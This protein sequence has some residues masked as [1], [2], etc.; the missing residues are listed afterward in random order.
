[1]L[2][3]FGG[4]IWSR[5]FPGRLCCGCCSIFSLGFLTLTIFGILYL[6]K[7]SFEVQELGTLTHV[8]ERTDPIK[9]ING[10]QRYYL[11]ERFQYRQNQICFLYRQNQSFSKQKIQEIIKEMKLGTQRRI[12]IRKGH[13]C[14]DRK[15]KQYYL[16]TGFG[17]LTPLL[18]ILSI[19]CCCCCLYSCYPLYSP[20]CYCCCVDWNILACCLR[21]WKL[22][23]RCVCCDSL[24][25]K[26]LR[27]PWRSMRP[28]MQRPQQDLDISVQDQT[29]DILFRGSRAEEEEEEEGQLAMTL[30]RFRV[31]VCD[32]S[33]GSS[34]PQ[35]SESDLF[36]DQGESLP[37]LSSLFAHSKSSP[38]Q[39]QQRQLEEDEENE[40]ED[41]EDEQKDGLEINEERRVS[42]I[43]AIFAYILFR[44][45][46]HRRASKGFAKGSIWSGV[47]EEEPS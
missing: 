41:R 37:S 18:L 5:S 6:S 16:W 19:L 12:W 45:A 1:M 10:E 11:R 9:S 15:L 22:I 8:D 2:S 26:Y 13:S 42:L 3:S 17:M 46:L 14:Y 35:S 38:S 47:C 25:W 30:K 33:E 20:L 28:H 4:K 32:I 39:Q 36:V 7:L 27:Y 44:S 24:C 21:Y 43:F 40:C 29:I 23:S 34:S 31:S